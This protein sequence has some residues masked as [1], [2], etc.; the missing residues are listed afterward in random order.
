VIVDVAE[1]VAK[2]ATVMFC[3]RSRLEVVWSHTLSKT[4]IL[5]RMPSKMGARLS[6]SSASEAP[7]PPSSAL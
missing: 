3:V 5:A 7:I 1:E 4:F 2:E 6:P